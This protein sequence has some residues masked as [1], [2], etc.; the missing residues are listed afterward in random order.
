MQIE[1][2]MSQYFREVRKKPLLSR[3]QEIA[4]GEQKDTGFKAR[5]QLASGS[6]ITKEQGLT[7]AK[8]IDAGD[9]AIQELTERNLRLVV[10]VAKK[11]RDLGLPFADLIQ[12]GNLG[13]M[14][15]VDKYDVRRGLKFSTYATWWIRQAINRA[16]HEQTDT[17]NV[18]EYV[19][20]QVK[21]VETAQEKK[22]VA[23]GQEPSPQE[24]AADTDLPV[25]KVEELNAL[26][27]RNVLS[28]E[29]TVTAKPK[30]PLKDLLP[31]DN[32]TVEEVVYTH[33]LKRLITGELTTLN[34][35]DKRAQDMVTQRF[36]LDGDDEKTLAEVG[37]SYDLSRERVRQIERQAL[38]QLKDNP[39]LQ[40]LADE[41]QRIPTETGTSTPRRSELAADEREKK[42]QA[43]QDYRRRFNEKRQ[44]N[45]AVGE[46]R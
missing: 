35:V 3:E 19:Q 16:V 46:R 1:S 13:L 45:R 17:M 2:E 4:L 22:R 32:P 37:V 36:G 31:S 28:L 30:T 39:T 26:S 9:T 38:R 6:F 12:E 43:S 33:E 41:E 21:K 27:Q 11:Y 23:T 14:K 29:M 18:P 15:A 20:L 24:I 10:S 25:T 7:L 40:A 34:R 42:R 8:D 44:Q 5:R